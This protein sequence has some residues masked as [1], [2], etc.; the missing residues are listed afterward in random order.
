MHLR[1]LA[2]ICASLAAF[3]ADDADPVNDL[4]FGVSILQAPT[5]SERVS[6]PG[7]APGA[8]YDWEDPKEW[9][10]RYEASYVQ[11]MSTRGRPASG[12]TWM[13]GAFYNDADI[14]PGGYTTGTGVSTD[15]TRDDIQLSLRQFGTSVGVGYSSAPSATS[16]GSWHWE[17]MPVGR[18][19]WATADTV[20]PG[21]TST[22]H[23][24]SNWFWEGGARAAVV[25]ADAGWILGLHV[26]WDYSIAYVDIDMGS[27][28][29]SRLTILRNGAQAG[30]E[31]GFR[32]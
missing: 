5:I 16:L 8:N 27:T 6:P 18:L 11:G 22:K 1:P 13:V 12:F 29:Q 25:L 31:I 7:N 15:N 4:R 24:D 28:G 2:L 20:T 3:A 14:T 30:A 17:L 32:F 10:L 23:S 9:H 26:G 19:G 21:F